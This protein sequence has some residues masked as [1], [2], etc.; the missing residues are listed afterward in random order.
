[1]QEQFSVVLEVVEQFNEHFVTAAPNLV[2][3]LPRSRKLEPIEKSFAMLKVQ[4]SEIFHAA[5]QLKNRRSYGHDQIPMSVWI[6]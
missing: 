6:L 5:K 3:K 1:M 4:K 2:S